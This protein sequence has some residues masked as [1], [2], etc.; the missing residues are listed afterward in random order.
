MIALEVCRSWK[1]GVYLPSQRTASRGDPGQALV[2]PIR[3]LS[4]ALLSGQSG[5]ASPF[6]P[7]PNAGQTVRLSGTGQNYWSEHWTPTAAHRMLFSSHPFVP[8]LV[9]WKSLPPS[10]RLSTCK[11]CGGLFVHPMATALRPIG[12]FVETQERYPWQNHICSTCLAAFFASCFLWF[13]RAVLESGLSLL[14][15][16][17]FMFWGGSSSCCG[18]R[19]SNSY[20]T[21]FHVG[22]KEKEGKKQGRKDMPFL[23]GVAED[24]VKRVSN[25]SIR[26][27]GW[28]YPVCP[29]GLMIS[30]K[31]TTS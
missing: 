11:T 29:E 21:H 16:W 30:D 18:I 10:P 17:G 23:F 6:S 9:W 28:N 15:S 1:R 27:F 31:I 19:K 26:K 24:S 22:K 8:A 14:P 2:C 4:P 20:E 7:S 12:A 3:R 25:S 13:L 5:A